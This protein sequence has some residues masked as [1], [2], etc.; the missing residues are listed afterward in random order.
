MGIKMAQQYF[1]KFSNIKFQENPLSSSS[2][3]LCLQKDHVTLPGAPQN[4]ANM[5]TGKYQTFKTCKCSKV[6]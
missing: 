6:I 5:I 2:V 1:V 4:H 3:V